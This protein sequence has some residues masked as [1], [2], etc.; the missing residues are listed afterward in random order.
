[1]AL[2]HCLAQSGALVL[3]GGRG[4]TMEAVAQGARSGGGRSIGLLPFAEGSGE[5]PNEFIDH[6]V[7]T[8]LG[9]ARNFL[10]AAVPDAAI[11]LAG[12]AGTLSEIGLALKLGTPLVYLG[13]WRFLN[14]HGLPATPYTEVAEEAVR[15]VFAALQLEPGQLLSQPLRRPTVSDQAANLLQLAEVVRSW[16]QR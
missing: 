14:D 1:V 11:A 2:G 3:C 7:F 13:A 4:G 5:R 15:L 10:M 6:A 8:G 9:D 12:E 16:S